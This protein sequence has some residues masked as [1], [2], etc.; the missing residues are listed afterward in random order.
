[1]TH[2]L[3]AALQHTALALMLAL[4]MFG[5]SSSA[6]AQTYVEEVRCR[7]GAPGYCYFQKAAK[8]GQDKSREL[9]RVLEDG[10][11]CKVLWDDPY[12]V[13]P[14]PLPLT[15]QISCGPGTV[16]VGNQC[17]CDVTQP[18]SP[19]AEQLRK[20]KPVSTFAAGGI[21]PVMSVDRACK[22]GF[23]N[24]KVTGMACEEFSILATPELWEQH[25]IALGGTSTGQPRAREG[26]Y[27]PYRVIKNAD[28]VW[29]LNGKTPK[30]STLVLVERK[31]CPWGFSCITY[32][33]FLA[34]IPSD[35]LQ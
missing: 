18:N 25:G 21:P 34:S 2:K 7:G 32:G 4:G 19:C 17:L 20:A 35:K 12:V 16:R 13:C 5:S 22:G 10:Y 28:G 3:Y 6:Q 27:Y 9:Q 1:M 30:N 33:E 29:E 8:Q 26:A 14:A 11:G 23:A 15:K 31:D 24:L